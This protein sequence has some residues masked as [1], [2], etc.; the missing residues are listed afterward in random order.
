MAE[1]LGRFWSALRRLARGI[2]RVLL[3]LAIVAAL[4]PPAL[5]FLFRY[6]QPPVTMF[7]L[8]RVGE[9]LLDGRL[10]RWPDRSTRSLD[11]ISPHLR[12]AVIAAEDGRFYLHHGFDFREIAEALEDYEKGQPLRGASTISQQTVKNIFLWEDRSMVR[13]GLEAYL[14][15]L[16]ELIL[17]KDRIIELYLN[18]AEWGEGVYGAEAAAQFHF[19]K[20]AASLTRDEAARLAAILPNPRRLKPRDP[21]LARRV[22]VIQSR[23]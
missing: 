22:S 3:I 16:A 7:M 8:E 6:F 2:V 10:P 20:S 9:A 21:R 14:T 11:A 5:L 1:R 13:K 12:R 15:V 19:A 4:L 18:L 17:G 23:M